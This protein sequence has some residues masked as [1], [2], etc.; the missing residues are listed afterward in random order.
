MPVDTRYLWKATLRQLVGHQKETTVVET[1]SAY[2]RA[3]LEAALAVIMARLKPFPALYIVPWFWDTPP[4]LVVAL[5]Q[6]TLYGHEAMT[7]RQ[8]CNALWGRSDQQ[9]LTRLNTLAARGILSPYFKPQPG[10]TTPYLSTPREYHRR[11]YFRRSDIL[12][13][14]Q[15]GRHLTAAERKRQKEA[16]HA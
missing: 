1:P 9:A 8:T 7:P 4:G 13:L 14:V 12:A 11:Q 6:W 5:A 3:E 16:A 10:V 2:S 15:S